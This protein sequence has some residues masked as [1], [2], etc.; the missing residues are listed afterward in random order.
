MRYKVIS[1]NPGTGVGLQIGGH[2]MHLLSSKEGY[3]LLLRGA[4]K[5]Y[6]D[7]ETKGFIANEWIEMIIE[8]REGKILLNINGSEKIYEH[9]K[10]SMDGAKTLLFKNSQFDAILFDYVRLWSAD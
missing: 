6:I 10:L 3:K 7:T 8:Y 4:G 5:T 1:K 9:D 2:K